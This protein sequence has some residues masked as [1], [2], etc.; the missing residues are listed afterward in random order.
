VLKA[1]WRLE[2]VEGSALPAGR[3]LSAGELRALFSACAADGSPA[4]ARDAALL[5][6]LYGGGLRRAE[7]IAL[8][9]ADYDRDDRALRVFGKRRKQRLAYL[10]AGGV[11]AID[12]WLCC[13]AAAAG[14]ELG[15]LA[16]PLLCP[17]LKGG[18]IVCRPMSPGAVLKRLRLRAAQAK[19]AGLSP[20]DLR[21]SFVSDLL[22]AGVDIATVQKMA[23]HAHVQTTARYDRRPEDAKRAAA[24]RLHVPFVELDADR[25]VP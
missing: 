14:V 11:S 4:G 10:D 5:A 9:I 13:R 1:A 24:Q 8:S 3:A 2:H 20:H 23:G 12:A 17:V 6:I 15:Q 22:D 18:R 21:R 16:G 7:A 25:R 19:V